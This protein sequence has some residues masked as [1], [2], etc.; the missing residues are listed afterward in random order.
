MIENTFKLEFDKE[1]AT[2]TQK[3][4]IKRYWDYDAENKGF[5][6]KVNYIFS[7]NNMSV[8]SNLKVI[9]RH[10]TMRIQHICQVCLDEYWLPVSSRARFLSGITAHHDIPNYFT[11]Q[12]CAALQRLE[13]QQRGIDKKIKIIKTIQEAYDSQLYNYLTSFEFEVLVKTLEDD[14]F[15]ITLKYYANE[16]VHE[17]FIDAIDKLNDLQLLYI[18]PK[19]KHKY[20]REILYA[21]ETKQILSAI[22]G[23]H[24]DST[25][26]IITEADTP[27]IHS[28]EFSSELKFFLHPNKN[29]SGLSPDFTTLIEIKEDIIL[30]KGTTFTAGGWIKNN[31]G[32]NVTIVPTEKIVNRTRSIPLSKVPES[33]GTLINNYLNNLNE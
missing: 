21:E 30:R 33:L 6:E 15:N 1:T 23:G 16:G 22:P 19:S 4:L 14:Y 9:N 32:I 29:K 20:Y 24:R 12:S 8:Q 27:S 17:T 25:F 7:E 5:K 10:S 13:Q 31:E 3:K 28:S 26:R 2:E 11:C 18:N